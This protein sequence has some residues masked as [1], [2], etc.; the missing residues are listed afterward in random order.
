[1]GGSGSSFI[2][3]TWVVG[4]L[5]NEILW[6]VGGIKIKIACLVGKLK[7]TQLICVVVPQ[8]Y[9]YCRFYATENADKPSRNPKRFTFFFLFLSHFFCNCIIS[10]VTGNWFTSPSSWRHASDQ[11]T[12]KQHS[13]VNKR[14][15]TF[16]SLDFRSIWRERLMPFVGFLNRQ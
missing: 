13:K 12:E 5:I 16:T 2:L 6:V 14:R 10:P 11:A 1:M 15:I 4:F 8:F 3:L 7:P 9:N